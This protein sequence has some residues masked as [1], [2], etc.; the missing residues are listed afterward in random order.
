MEL[1][2]YIICM[3]VDVILI[4]IL[5]DDEC[6]LWYL[7]KVWLKLLWNCIEFL[8][9]SLLEVIMV[10]IMYLKNYDFVYLGMI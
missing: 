4:I 7:V 5:G 6:N 8:D 3:G 1:V 2:E 9:F 10:L